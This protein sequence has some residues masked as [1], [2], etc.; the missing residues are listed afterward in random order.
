M[1]LAIISG[2]GGTGKTTIA[3]ALSE[4]SSNKIGIDCDVDAPNFYLFYQGQDIK[5]NTFSG[6]KI[7]TIDSSICKNCGLC[8]AKCKF[9]A[10][11]DAVI[12]PFL[13][14]GCGLC[15]LVC[16]FNA[17]QMK[18]EVTAHTFL[19]ETDQ[20]MLSRAEME[21][22]S[23]G[24]GKLITQ[25]RKEVKPYQSDNRLTI[26][27]GSPG[28]G[29]A[30]IASIT[31][32]DF[33][34]LVTEPTQS[35]LSDLKRIYALCE[36]FGIKAMLCI[37]K[38]DVHE[39]MTDTIKLFANEKDIQVVGEIP[40]DNRVVEAINALKPITHYTD[41]SASRAIKAMWEKIKINIKYEEEI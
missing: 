14:E 23:D 41:S 28:I 27:D 31:A 24:S 29:C 4:L 10:I 16:P 9:G 15:A 18:E 7:A 19:T 11:S 37:N 34:L 25:L 13:C 5:K 30:V 22:G 39:V 21:I 17:I 38:Y 40:Y 26:L 3:S 1:E 35:G 12:N 32:V 8:E 20:S 2:K 6:G 33:V 36:H